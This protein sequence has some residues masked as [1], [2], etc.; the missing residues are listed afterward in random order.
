MPQPTRL[1]DSTCRRRRQ[2]RARRSDDSRRRRARGRLRGHRL[3]RPQRQG[4][5]ARGDVAPASAPRPSRCATFPTSPR[6]R[7][8][9]GAARPSASSCRTSTASSSPRSFAGST[10]RRGREGYHILVSGSH[11]DP[12][13]MLDVRRHHARPRR[14]AGGHGARRDARAARR[15]CARAPC[16]SSCSTP[17]TTNGDAITIDNYGG[18]RAMMRHLPSSG[19]RASPS[20]A[21]RS[22]TP[23]RASGCAATA[24]PCA[25]WRRRAARAGVAAATSPRSRATRRRRRSPSW[26]P[27]PTAVFAANDSMAVG[28][29][30]SLA[31][32]G[33][34][35]PGEMTRRR[36]RRHPDRALRH[37]A[38]DDD[39]RRHRGARARARS[40]CC[41][42][43]SA[44]RAAHTP[45][46]ERVAT[47]L[48]VRKSCGARNRNRTEHATAS[49]GA[50]PKSG[51]EKGEVS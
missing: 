32:A 27:R 22:R 39:P 2:P 44:I 12:A 33:V 41:S 1:S 15:A 51:P 17:P 19:T 18:A 40:R 48:V 34:E 45:R 9:S 6:A 31:A 50:W 10:W 25:A 4:A 8:A 30:A 42:T 47:T 29:L 24:T 20:S 13:Q 11:S 49:C 7:S 3:P 36:L 43:P 28:V 16:R 35:V 26:T 21:G 23:T 14:R 46:H 5:R 37:A 38:A